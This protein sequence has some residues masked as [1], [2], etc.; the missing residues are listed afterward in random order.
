MKR[1]FF[2]IIDPLPYLALV[3]GFS[4]PK[5]KFFLN[6]FLAKLGIFKAILKDHT[7]FHQQGGRGGLAFV[8]N[9]EIMNYWLAPPKKTAVL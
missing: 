3:T 2:P 5:V 4:G 7:S 6:P 8:E 1:N 9:H